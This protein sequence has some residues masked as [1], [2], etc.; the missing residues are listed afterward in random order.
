MREIRA[1]LN[2][3]V[4]DRRAIARFDSLFR[5]AYDAEI[6]GQSTFRQS[7]RGRESSVRV[8][9]FGAEEDIY[10]TDVRP[11]AKS[12]SSQTRLQASEV[13]DQDNDNAPASETTP[14]QVDSMPENTPANFNVETPSS[15]FAD[16]APESNSNPTHGVPDSDTVSTDTQP[17]PVAQVAVANS[18]AM[19]PGLNPANQS[20]TQTDPDGL[21][22]ES[23]TVGTTSSNTDSSNDN[24]PANDADGSNGTGG[25][26][27]D[28]GA[29]GT[30]SSS[31]TSGSGSSGGGGDSGGD[32]GGD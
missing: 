28:G 31:G 6:F 24:A 19:E 13:N 15:G 8:L 10:G 11:G 12:H 32:G 14:S 29:S 1:L 5:E 3:D 27:N 2:E 21:N 18:H 26:S 9:D 7:N 30:S 17:A 22:A 16:E 25:T 20:D 4:R 23:D